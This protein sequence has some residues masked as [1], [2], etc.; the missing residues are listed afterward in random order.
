MAT[1]QPRAERT[2]DVIVNCAAQVFDRH[3]Y[4]ST[5]L[6]DVLALGGVTK[7]A[8]YFHFKSKEDLAKAVVEQHQAVL[9]GPWSE[10]LARDGHGLESIILLS[11]D[12]AGRLLNDVVVRAG[13]RL[14]LEQGTFG[15]DLSDSYGRWLEVIEELARRSIDE[16]DIR[17]VVDPAS[18]ARFLVATFTGV[19]LVSQV[20]TGRADL[21]RRVHQMWEIVLPSLVMS[22]KLPHFRRIAVQHDPAYGPARDGVR[23]G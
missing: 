21:V 23:L 2:R 22:R 18:L 15:A 9:V 12:F 11:N 14:T 3:G 7:G 19:Q 17:S 1:R 16:G 6:S 4:G 20:T 10:A 5:T 8:L 13:V